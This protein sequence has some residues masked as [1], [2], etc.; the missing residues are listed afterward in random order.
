MLTLTTFV[1]ED[2]VAVGQTVTLRSLEDSCPAFSSVAEMITSVSFW[3][4]LSSDCPPAK[5]LRKGWART[6]FASARSSFVR[7]LILSRAPGVLSELG[8][9]PMRSWQNSLSRW[10]YLIAITGSAPDWKLTI[11][12]GLCSP[13]FPPPAVSVSTEPSRMKWGFLLAL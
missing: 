8:R 2:Q 11:S 10:M 7:F 5:D 4:D 1:N 3:T 9:T 13:I 12:R 6:T